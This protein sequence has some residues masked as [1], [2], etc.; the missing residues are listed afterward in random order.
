MRRL[1]GLRDPPRWG[2]GRGRE[3]G[4][5]AA[6]LRPLGEGSACAPSP[7]AR[8][9]R[10][11]RSPC[12]SLA[13]GRVVCTFRRSPGLRGDE[14]RHRQHRHGFRSQHGECLPSPGAS[15]CPAAW[16]RRRPRDQAGGPRC[17]AELTGRV[18]RAVLAA[19]ASA[20]PRACAPWAVVGSEPRG[21]RAFLRWEGVRAPRSGRPGRPRAPGRPRGRP[22][23]ARAARGRLASL[24]TGAGGR[25]RRAQSRGSV[26]SG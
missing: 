11:R 17:R 3:A 26:C 8:G 10:G 7:A 21:G 6:Q 19:P 24:A 23:G 5:A 13:H 22:P 16:A 20:C 18:T 15:P 9:P 4:A 25:G 14:H 2:P 1:Y 12:P